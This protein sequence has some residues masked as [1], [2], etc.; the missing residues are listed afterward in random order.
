M[1]KKLVT[2]LLTIAATIM[3]GYLFLLSWLLGFL[4]TKH[5]AGKSVGEQG[6]VR[7]VIIPFIRGWGIHL[8]HWLYSLGL[9]GFSSATGIHFLTPTITYGLL[10]GLVFQGIY[11]YS[12]WHV[13]LNKRTPNKSEIPP[14]PAGEPGERA[15]SATPALEV[16]T[17]EETSLKNTDDR[18]A[19]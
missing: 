5:V 19:L 2:I 13:I 18:V 12:D 11:C 6:K 10:G 16:L 1:K 7:S 14:M 4:A 17:G 3:L 8:H 9:I 15:L